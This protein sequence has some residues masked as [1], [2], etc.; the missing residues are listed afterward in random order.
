MASKQEP[1]PIQ[2]VAELQKASQKQRDLAPALKNGNAELL[3]LATIVSRRAFAMMQITA[4]LQQTNP[5]LSS[6]APQLAV[7]IMYAANSPP[8]KTARYRATAMI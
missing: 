3:V 2:I 5:I 8:A 6:H 7:Q 4:E 1:A